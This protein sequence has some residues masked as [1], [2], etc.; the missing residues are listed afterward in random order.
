MIFSFW[1]PTSAILSTKR[2]YNLHL[3]SISHFSTNEY[4]EIISQEFQKNLQPNILYIQCWKPQ[5]RLGTITW[6]E[7]AWHIQLIWYLQDTFYYFL[8]YQTTAE[9]TSRSEW[10]R[11]IMQALLNMNSY[12]YGHRVN[13]KLP[14]E[15]I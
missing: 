4:I 9:R 8:N 15:L 12:G 7:N 10:D 11:G 5:N 13:L 3:F 14:K 6:H 2:Q 1:A